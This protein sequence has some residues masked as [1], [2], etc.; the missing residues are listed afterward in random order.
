[1]KNKVIVSLFFAARFRKLKRKFPL[2]NNELAELTEMLILNPKLGISLGANLYKIRLS[3]KSKGGGKSGGFRVVTLAIE[4]INNRFE[5]TLITI[6]DKSEH[7]NFTKEEL[8][9]IVKRIHSE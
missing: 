1:M 3:S 4:E 6:Y 7:Q 8:L 2:L 9:K 5:I